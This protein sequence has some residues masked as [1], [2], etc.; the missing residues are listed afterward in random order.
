[1]KTIT[2][3]TDKENP[4]AILTYENSITP[5]ELLETL[6]S[7]LDLVAVEAGYSVTTSLSEILE[8]E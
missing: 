5:D 4:Q 2:I 6:F 8:A 1:M 3:S 7:M